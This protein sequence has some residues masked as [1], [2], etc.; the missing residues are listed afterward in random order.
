V[1]GW[2]PQIAF[3]PLMNVSATKLA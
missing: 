3:Q 1:K 2:L